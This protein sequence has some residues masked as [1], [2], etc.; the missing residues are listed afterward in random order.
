LLNQVRRLLGLR[1]LAMPDE[2]LTAAGQALGA[3]PAS[4]TTMPAPPAPPPPE[5]N[6]MSDKLRTALVALLG[7][8]DHDDAILAAATKAT[9]ALAMLGDLMKQFGATDP[10]DLAVKAGAARDAAGKT[11]DF[12][13]KLSEA[14]A[15]LDTGAEEE[16]KTETEQIAAS[17]GFAKDDPRGK[18]ARGV[19]FTLGLSARRA[20]LGI[21]IG[22]DG[23]TLTLAAKD[24]SRLEAFRAEYP[25][26]T[27]E[28]GRAAL[29]TT[30]I[31]AGTGGVQLG[32]AHT[33]LTPG[34]TAPAA[35][36][37]PAHLTEIALYPGANNIQKAIAM[38]SDKQPG[39]KLQPW[40][41]Q[42][43]I[44]GNFVATGK[45]A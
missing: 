21:A 6:T 42:N 30:P 1:A 7:V 27:A 38:L 18:S 16:T 15:A 34:G 28:Q 40:S 13:T 26:P 23:K 31:A 35:G 3:L 14:L 25:L 39:F 45:A 12:A 20:A 11:A 4:T 2:I 29:L 22:A 44:A 17:L 37:G 32:G 33:G 24:P 41:E 9:G 8:V 36:A 43:R 10:A 5:A 19:I